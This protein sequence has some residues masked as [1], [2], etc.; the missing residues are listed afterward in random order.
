MDNITVL[1]MPFCLHI[2]CLAPF[3]HHTHA[4]FHHHHHTSQFGTYSHSMG[5]SGKIWPGW[6]WFGQG[7]MV[8]GDGDVPSC[9]ISMLVLFLLLPGRKFPHLPWPGSCV[10]VPAQPT[11]HPPPLF[12]CLFAVVIITCVVGSTYPTFTHTHPTVVVYYPT[13]FFVDYH[14]YVYLPHRFPWL[15]IIGFITCTFTHCWFWFHITTTGSF[16][17]PPPVRWFYVYWTLPYLP[18]GIFMAWRF[19]FCILVILFPISSHT[20]CCWTCLTTTTLPLQ[21]L[22][23]SP[24]YC[25]TF[26]PL[27]PQLFPIVVLPC[28]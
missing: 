27:P 25:I 12:T 7:W 10:L 11:H 26:L 15:L 24:L 4:P 3:T 23:P 19:D 18:I 17:S 16:T 5:R 8:S 6:W 22:L 28:R 1:G 9:S 14:I 21:L 2:L 13:P 20:I